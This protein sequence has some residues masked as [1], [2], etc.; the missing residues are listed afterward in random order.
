MTVL[1][2][3]EQVKNPSQFLP[4]K[5]PNNLLD[6]GEI[7]FNKTSSL[8]VIVKYEI[9]LNLLSIDNEDTSRNKSFKEISTSLFL[10]RLIIASIISGSFVLGRKNLAR[11]TGIKVH[12]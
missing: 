12:S 6:I 5:L 10:V 11:Y 2:D 3:F 1:V 9:N 7:S 8:P 4:R